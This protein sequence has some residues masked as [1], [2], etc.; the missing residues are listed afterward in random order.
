MA[1]GYTTACADAAQHNHLFFIAHTVSSDRLPQPPLGA[2][3]N[4]Y[5]SHTG[6]DLGF[7]NKT[8][9]LSPSTPVA[10]STP[11]KEHRLGEH[12]PGLNV[13]FVMGAGAARRAGRRAARLQQRERLAFYSGL[14]AVVVRPCHVYGAGA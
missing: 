11:R 1:F 3:S 12:D 13:P 9:T 5:S 7:S 14:P 4:S 8:S 6:I 2:T 10:I